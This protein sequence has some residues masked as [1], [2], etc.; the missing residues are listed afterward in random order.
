MVLVQTDTKEPMIL[1]VGDIATVQS[2]QIYDF[3]TIACMLSSANQI[4]EILIALLAS[5]N[6]LGPNKF[7]KA[8][9]LGGLPWLIGSFPCGFQCLESL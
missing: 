9:L 6:K 3:R 4:A 1:T 7:K 2:Q 5:R 8:I